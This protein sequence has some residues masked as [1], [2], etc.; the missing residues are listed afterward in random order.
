[1]RQSESGD[2][3]KLCELIRGIRIGLLTTVGADGGFHTRPVETLAVEGGT[4][5]FFTDW[6]S[7]KIDE[8]HHDQRVC[9][10]YSDPKKHHYVALSG[11]AALLRDADKARELWTL[12]QRAY[13]PDGPE[14][15]R[16][17]LLRVEIERAEYWIAPGSIS[18]LVSAAKAAITGTP[19]QTIGE[20]RKIK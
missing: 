1:M 11:I 5:W 16:L 20:N 6:R 13:Y 17:A 7:P 4:L 14:D 3:S 18:Y 2:L 10:G 12:E 19:V 8:L 9:L 15:A